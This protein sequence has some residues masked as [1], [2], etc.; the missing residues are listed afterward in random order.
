YKVKDPA[1]LSNN[2]WMSLRD[3]EWR[4]REFDIKDIN[5]KDL[6]RNNFAIQLG[7]GLPF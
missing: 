2:G 3:F 6:K 7:I 4:N 5:G 1:R